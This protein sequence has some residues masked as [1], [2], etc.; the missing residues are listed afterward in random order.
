M[1]VKRTTGSIAVIVG[2]DDLAP[3]G[4]T[5]DDQGFENPAPWQPA[6]SSPAFLPMAQVFDPAHPLRMF[7]AVRDSYGASR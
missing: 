5:L 2:L 6:Q 1:A 3:A 4:F 7:E